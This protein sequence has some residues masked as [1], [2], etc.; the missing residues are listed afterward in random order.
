MIVHHADG[1]HV[2]VQNGR[3]QKFKTALLHVFRKSI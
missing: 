3:A 1:L 2:R